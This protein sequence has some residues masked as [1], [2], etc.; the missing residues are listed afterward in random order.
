MRPNAAKPKTEG[1]GEFIQARE[2][3]RAIKLLVALGSEI[4][5]VG[6][7][8]FRERRTSGE[9]HS[10]PMQGMLKTAEQPGA[11]RQRLHTEH[12]R[13]VHKENGFLSYGRESTAQWYHRTRVQ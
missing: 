10:A 12:V 9:A 6:K 7:G 5:R 4:T 13:P 1:C 2:P 11:A 3:S 8:A